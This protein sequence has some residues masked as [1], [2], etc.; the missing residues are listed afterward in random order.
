[1]KFTASTL[2][3][4]WLIEPKAFSDPRGYFM[5]AYRQDLFEQHVGKIAFVQD[6]E[7]KSTRGVLR[8]LHYQLPP[9]AQSKL[10]RVV[11]GA[12]LDVAVDIRAGSPTFGQHVAVALTAE[13]RRQLFIPQ[14]FAHGFLVL[15]SEAIFT[16]KVDNLY[17]PQHERSICFD[18]PAIGIDW[19]MDTRQLLLS[20]KDRSRAKPLGEA[21]LF[22]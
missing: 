12:A 3:G 18:D 20:E 22:L 17:A 19:G 14:G 8:G 16:Y 15:S 7:S 13:N 11:S 4:V 5:E 6:N 9:L 10:V 2:Q 1:M 21:E